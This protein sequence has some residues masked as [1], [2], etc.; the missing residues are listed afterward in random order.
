MPIIQIPI[1]D[2]KDS[3]MRPIV[4][5]ITNDLFEV[6]QIQP[7]PKLLYTDES[8]VEKQIG[9][10]LQ[11]N[12]LNTDF[13]ADS[14]LTVEVREELDKGMVY[15]QRTW[16]PEYLPIFNDEN[17]NIIIKPIYRETWLTF[18][19]IYRAEDKTKA[20]RWRDTIA[21]TFIDYQNVTHHLLTYH[22]LIPEEILFTLKEIHGKIEKIAGYGISFSDYLKNHM[23]NRLTWITDQAGKNRRLGI[24]EKQSD[25]YGE[26]DTDV[27]LEKGEKGENNSTWSVNFSYKVHFSKITH[28][29]F[30]YPQVIHQQPLEYP[31]VH[32]TTQQGKNGDIEYIPESNFPLSKNK[33]YSISSYYLKETGSLL[34]YAEEY[35]KR[36]G[37]NIPRDDEFYPDTVVQGTNNLVT[38]QLIFEETDVNKIN[39]NLLDL[40]DIPEY[41]INKKVLNFMYGEVPYMNIPTKSVFQVTLY[42]QWG[43]LDYKNIYVDQNL[44]VRNKKSINLRN[45][46][47]LRFGVYFDLSQLDADALDRLKNSGLMDLIIDKNSI[48]GNPY[49][50][51]TNLGNAQ[52]MKT[53]GI[54]SIESYYNEQNSNTKTNNSST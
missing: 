23:T 6:Y 14:L 43:Q 30:S 3:I 53:V 47:H 24:A 15:A 7:K 5:S 20:Q 19:F 46:Y 45:N 31:L 8:G 29:C 37:I 22:Y 44:I 32:K 26:L 54:Y 13:G 18:D 2:S 50:S 11:E 34:R 41:Y 28:L 12:S 36:K 49:E 9:T 25:V 10:A 33:F 48:T 1:H 52:P 4:T 40:K 39:L 16:M 35:D 42:N 27:E 17:L 38:A 51:Q 21:N